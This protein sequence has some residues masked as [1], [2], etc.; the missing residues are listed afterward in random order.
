MIRRLVTM[1]PE[2]YEKLKTVVNNTLNVEKSLSYHVREAI[3]DYINKLI[4]LNKN[5]AQNQNIQD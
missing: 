5:N 2:L 3:K 1:P 4:K